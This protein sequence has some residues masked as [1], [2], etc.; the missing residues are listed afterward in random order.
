[1]VHI[2]T[3]TSYSGSYYL[4]FD[5]QLPTYKLTF[6]LECMEVLLPHRNLVFFNGKSYEAS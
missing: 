6:P 4:Q 3:T 5:W 1:M 2:P